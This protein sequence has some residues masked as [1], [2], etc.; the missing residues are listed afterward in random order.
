MNEHGIIVGEGLMMDD[1]V[2]LGYPVAR[3][4]PSRML[5]IGPG[6]HLRS[7]TVIYLGSTIGR[8]LETGHNVVIREETIIGDEVCIWSNSV[9]DYRCRIGHRVRIHAGV[10]VAQDTVIEDDVF[11]APGV[12]IGNE[13]YPGLELDLPWQPVTIRRGAQIGVNATLRPGVIIGEGALVGSGSVVT[14]DVPPGVIAYGNPA[15]VR[16]KTADLEL[17]AKA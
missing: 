6:A 12:V 13:M 16:G 14:R 2:R 4:I 15:R 10:Y 7:G 9:I 17:R 11:L 1:G 8:N 3:E 5:H